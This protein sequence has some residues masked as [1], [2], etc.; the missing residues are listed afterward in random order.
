M[1]AFL[2]NLLKRP[3]APVLLLIIF[4]LLTGAFIFRDY[5]L[6]LDE[7]LYY[8]YAD[9]LGYAYSP[10]EWFSGDFN[11][12][13]AF[14]PSASD[15]QNRGPAYLLLARIPVRFLQNAP[16][17]DYPSAWHLV[18]FISFQI[19]V[20]FFFVFSCRWMKNRAAFAAT[21]L[22]ATQPL[23]WGH[24]F[25]NPK[26]PPFLT[27]FLTSLELGFRMADRISNPKENERVWTTFTYII[28][29]AVVVG[30][31]TNL[32]VLGP[33]A[34]LLVFVYFLFLRKPA[35][36]YWFIPYGL[37]ALATLITTWPFLWGDPIP[38][39][40]G[41]FQFF[42]DNPTELRVLF[43][44]EIYTADNLPLRYLPTLLAI[45]LTEPVWP[46]AIAGFFVSIRRW[47]RKAIEWKTLLPTLLWFI[48]PFIYV[49]I[50][51]PAM[52]DG[53]RHSLYILPPVFVLAG[54]FLDAIFEHVSKF[55]LKAA[56]I[57]LLIL[58]AIQADIQLH[59]Y[60]YT[61]YNQ[62]VGGT[63]KAS[64]NY[65]TDYWSTCYKDAAQE[66]AST[67]TNK[68]TLYVG[69]KGI[70]NL[71]YYAN[72]NFV[73]KEYQPRR[74]N[75]KRGYVLSSSRANNKLPFFDGLYDEDS[76]LIERDGAI[77]CEIRKIK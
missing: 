37:V 6:T 8:Q 59:P 35:R 12:E 15:H 21:L 1:P 76:I 28:F 2:R 45:T 67:V 48:V 7:P 61:Y 40:L 75:Y 63:G 49:F 11:L 52:Y 60:Q 58:P 53:F 64:H 65:E 24:A 26:D 25:I 34:G 19:G 32:R 43:L 62:F 10:S 71:R 14:G 39:L 13:N 57:G 72:Q 54:I 22:F 55:Y 70:D 9:S 38:N 31:A 50:R 74:H 20:Y 42:S 44:G 73:V 18:N 16:G 47:Q 36:F 68:P 77:F 3:N 30:F 23:L 29:P 33:L 27:A 4:N 56:L 5:G 17:M 41:A 69:G 51:Q 66:F 46:L